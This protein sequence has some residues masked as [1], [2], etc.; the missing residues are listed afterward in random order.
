MDE[1]KIVYNYSSNSGICGYFNMEIRIDTPRMLNYNDNWV[2]NEFAEKIR[3]GIMTETVKLDP[4][5]TKEANEEKERLIALFGDKKIFVSEIPNGYDPESWYYSRFPWF[6][7]T[8]EK[9]HIK[10]GWRKRVIEIDWTDSIIKH[11][12][13]YL[14]PDEDVTK[15]EKYIHAWGYDKAQE[16]INKLL[17]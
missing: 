9:G 5:I 1:D 6:I 7:V 14:F 15:G 13:E 17:N 10:L 8:T 2:I 16:Y 12:A 3:I 4:K 11:E